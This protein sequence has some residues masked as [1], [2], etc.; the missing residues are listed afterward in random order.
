MSFSV[1]HNSFSRFIVIV[2]PFRISSIVAFLTILSISPPE[3]SYSFA[4]CFAFS[5]EIQFNFDFQIAVFASTVGFSNLI[6]YKNLRS[7][8]ASYLFQDLL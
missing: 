3:K 8:A 1:L 2:E 4:S 5:S 7:N 6:L